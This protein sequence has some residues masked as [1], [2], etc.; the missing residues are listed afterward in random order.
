MDMDDNEKTSKKAE[1][2]PSEIS[3]EI[4]ENP[5]VEDP[6]LY[7]PMQ[8]ADRPAPEERIEQV[9]ESTG[10]TGEEKPP[11]DKAE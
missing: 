2:T 7:S 8:E 3:P 5:D 4:A 9:E 1:K 10:E 6:R 11:T